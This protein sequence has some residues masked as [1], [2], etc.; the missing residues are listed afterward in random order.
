[1]AKPGRMTTHRSLELLPATR[2]FT[3]REEPRAAFWTQY[4]EKKAE[5]FF[6]EDYVRVLNYYGFGGIGKTALLKKLKEEL[7]EKVAAPL[8]VSYDFTTSTD[9]QTM[10]KSLR[11]DLIL[12]YNYNFPLFDIG[13]YVYAQKC[14]EKAVSLEKES[15]VSSNP[16]LEVAVSVADHIP[17]VS[18]ITKLFT[19]LDGATA[20]GRTQ[21]Y[22]KKYE[23]TIRQ[24]EYMERED[25]YRQLP[26]L[27]AKDL[28]ENLEDVTEPLVIF[29]DTYEL[30]VNEM[31]TVGEPLMADL[32]LRGDQGLIQNIPK[33]IWVIAGREKLKWDRFD[34]AW[35]T[36]IDSHIL[37]TLSRQDSISF[38]QSAGIR[39][40]TLCRQLYDLTGGTPVYLDLCVGC[41]EKL[42]KGGEPPHISQFGQNTQELVERFVRYMDGTQKDLV[43]MTACLGKW[44]DALFAAIAPQVLKGWSHT[45][46]EKLKDYSFVTVLDDG[47]YAIHQTIRTVLLEKC[48]PSVKLATAKAMISYF[49]N[50]LA[51]SDA[52]SFDYPSALWQLVQA[53]FWLHSDRAQYYDFYKRSIQ[54][55][56]SA[57]IISSKYEAAF[58]ILSLLLQEAEKCEDDLFY[59]TVAH[60]RSVYLI[61]TDDQKAKEYLEKVLGIY[62]QYLG[63]DHPDTLEVMWHLSLVLYNLGKFDASL[64]L[65]EALL[66]KR[67][68]IL[69]E[70]HPDTLIVMSNLSIWYAAHRRFEDALAVNRHLQE[71]TDKYQGEEWSKTLVASANLTESYRKMGR[72]EEALLAAQNAFEKSRAFLGENHCDTMRLATSLIEAYENTE[73]Y[74]NALELAQELLDKQQQLLGD[75][76]PDTL[77]TM[78][79]MV[80][81]L[82]KTNQPEEALALATQLL[83][84]RTAFLGEDHPS[85]L[86]TMDTVG[87]VLYAMGRF[88]EMLRLQESI[89]ELREQTLEEDHPDS[90]MTMNNMSLALCALGSYG[91]S[92]QV[93]QVTAEKATAKLGEDDPVTL[94]ARYNQGRALGCMGQFQEAL[95]V[96]KDVLERRTRVLGEAHPHTQLIMQNTV[97]TLFET[98][99]YEEALVLAQKLLAIRT[100]R[101]GLEHPDTLSAMHSV[102]AA[103][104]CLG[105]FE[106]SLPLTRQLLEIRTRTLG[107]TDPG[108][109]Q[110]TDGLICILSKLG[111]TEEAL[112]M[113]Q[114][115]LAQLQELFEEDHPAV[116][117]ATDLIAQLQDI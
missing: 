49:S 7:R 98:E 28:S 60:A 37:G 21:A 73:D 107:K 63:A 74:S 11:T 104:Y 85:T 66:E 72:F 58:P 4:E 24:L 40:E 106:E 17:G 34:P 30:L 43:Y 109:L 62:Q 19:T 23:Q 53:G 8:Y 55:P 42:P 31:C 47:C 96:Q 57:L 76:H 68:R 50:V 94:I 88:E 70:D 22:L 54:K 116:L 92:L 95:A 12:R 117:R 113:A 112:P 67:T 41:F 87:S 6:E 89:L 115:L 110:T 29:L 20:W 56:L 39:D 25:V 52:L 32:W 86:S 38:L 93:A 69:G 114:A 102:G 111:M 46:Y 13:L 1:M 61:S 14:G 18:F 64:T 108:T 51:E 83:E 100:E 26:G 35:D 75:T 59:A 27:F 71:K 99:D 45:V 10:L 2:I 97:T 16:W 33:L 91:E 77:R 48:L 15:L 9:L 79:N 80:D 81:T 82:V 36:V 90:L 105:R 65:T 5:L 3:D 103:L 101:L 78:H 44:D 84:K